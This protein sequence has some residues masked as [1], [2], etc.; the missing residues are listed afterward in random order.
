MPSL[1]VRELPEIIYNKLKLKAELEHRTLAQQAIVT[2]AKGLD[3]T[4][5]P[6]S[7]RTTLLKLIKANAIKLK[8]FQLSDPAKL[9]REDRER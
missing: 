7:R 9:I 3:V 8:K 4:F 1:Q 5:D 6:I 2:L